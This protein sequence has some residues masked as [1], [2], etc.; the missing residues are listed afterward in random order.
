[1]RGDPRESFGRNAKFYAKSQAH[2]EEKSLKAL[3][4]LAEVRRGQTSLDVAT[5]A[6][7]TAATLARAGASVTAL[8][9]TPEMLQEA[10]TLYPGLGI[11]WVL[12]DVMGLPFPDGAFDI[13]VS[14]RAP[15]HFSDIEGALRSM[16]S[17]LKHGGCLIIDDR[18]VPEDD[19]VDQTMN[20]LDRLHDRSH[21]REY[22]LAEWVSMLESTGLQVLHAERY[23]RKRPLDSLTA[24]ARKEDAKEIHEMVDGLGEAGRRRMG[25]EVVGGEVIVTHWFVLLKALKP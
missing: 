1:M 19:F 15:H 4:D 8:D 22:R 20:H 13:V 5:G 3:T 25:I 23:E 9:I 24:T 10:R 16:A 7:H 21:V 2:T 18:S 12:G 11:G 6:G 17:A 14:R